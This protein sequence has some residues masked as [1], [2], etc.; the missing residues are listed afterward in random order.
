MCEF[1]I[2]L[3]IPAELDDY[4]SVAEE[5]TMHGSVYKH[6]PVDYRHFWR[7]ELKQRIVVPLIGPVGGRKEH[8]GSYNDAGIHFYAPASRCLS[9]S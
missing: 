8:S 5:M 6:I 9:A 1:N 3:L 2:F 4:E 7:W